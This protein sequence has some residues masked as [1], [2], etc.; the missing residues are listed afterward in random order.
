M[1]FRKWL[2]E[3]IYKEP[4]NHS[5]WIDNCIFDGYNEDGSP[6]IVIEEN[7]FIRVKMLGW[8]CVGPKGPFF[9]IG[10]I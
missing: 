4:A 9:H 7:K 1:N 8:N 2:A 5:V 3:L 6:P 10:K